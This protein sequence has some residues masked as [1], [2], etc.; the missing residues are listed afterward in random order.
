MTVLGTI[1]ALGFALIRLYMVMMC[2]QLSSWRLYSW[3]RLTW[4]HFHRE[5]KRL[6]KFIMNEASTWIS[7]KEA[8]LTGTPY[9]FWRYWATFILFSCLTVWTALWNPES[10]D[11]DFNWASCSKWQIHSSPIC[12]MNQYVVLKPTVYNKTGNYYLS[13]NVR[14]GWIAKEE[15]TTRSNT[16]GLVLELF[17]CHLVKITETETTFGISWWQQLLYKCKCNWKVA[18]ISLIKISEWIW[19]TPL[20]ACEPTIAR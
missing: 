3:M 12:W 18:Y 20:T 1:L 15:P 8:G 17:R 14:Q 11:R 4:N 9:S 10:E 6:L 19:A 13:N 7:N 16:V 5:N 2:R